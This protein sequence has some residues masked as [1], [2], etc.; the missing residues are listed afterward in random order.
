MKRVLR[1]IFTGFFLGLA[2]CL[3]TLEFLLAWG[4]LRGTLYVMKYG[5]G[6]N[7]YAAEDAEIMGICAL[8]LLPLA[9]AALAWAVYRTILQYKNRAEAQAER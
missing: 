1:I 6:E 5:A 4:W 9:L 3:T 2:V 7:P 8:A